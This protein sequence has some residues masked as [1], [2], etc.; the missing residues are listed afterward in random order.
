MFPGFQLTLCPWYFMAAFHLKLKTPF[1]FFDNW[2][3]IFQA[4]SKDKQ[5][6]EMDLGQPRSLSSKWARQW[7]EWKPSSLKG[8]VFPPLSLS[9]RSLSET[10]HC[11]RCTKDRRLSSWNFSSCS[12]YLLPLVCPCAPLRQVWRHLFIYPGIVKLKFQQTT[13]L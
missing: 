13:F 3:H 5:Q 4:V 1:L 2:S 10:T 8:P 9:T 12:F 7:M 11:K 6:C